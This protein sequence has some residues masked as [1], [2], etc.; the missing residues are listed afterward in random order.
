VPD[1]AEAWSAI[2]QQIWRIGLGHE[3]APQAAYPI[4]PAPGARVPRHARA[5]AE[6]LPA[7]IV[8]DDASRALVARLHDAGP[9]DQRATPAEL[10]RVIAR[11]EQHI[12]ADTALDEFRLRPQIRRRLVATANTDLASL[13][14]WIY[15]QVFAT[16]GSDPWLGLRARTEFTGLPG[17]GVV[18][19]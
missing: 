10:A 5:A 14:A 8:L 12:V 17:D 6:A 1:E 7:S 16:P 13:N 9:A 2:G 18:M 3:P 15:D 11:L 19:P 4:V